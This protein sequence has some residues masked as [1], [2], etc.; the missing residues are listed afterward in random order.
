MPVPQVG[1]GSARTG[2]MR[3]VVA[4]GASGRGVASEGIDSACQ[5]GDGVILSSP[6]GG[7][8]AVRNPAQAMVNDLR[9]CAMQRARSADERI[10]YHRANGYAAVQ[11]GSAVK[12]QASG[13]GRGASAHQPQWETQAKRVSRS[14]SED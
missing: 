9:V 14:A 10:V 3:V 4:G 13:S 5:R 11:L 7:R 1:M 6:D 12:P 8:K 2:T